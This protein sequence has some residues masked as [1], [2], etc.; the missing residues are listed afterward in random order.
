MSNPSISQLPSTR[1]WLCRLLAAALILGSAALRIAFMASPDCLDL[2]PDEGHYWDW[3]RHPDWSYYSK[4][5]VV[6]L[7]I[8]ASCTL[9]EQ[10]T[11]DLPGQAMLSVRL[12]AVLCGC[13]LLLSVYV[14][15]VLVFQREAWALGAVALGLTLPPIT[16]VSEIMTIDAPYLCCWSWGL[17]F[18]YLALF[19]GKTWGWPL[20]GLMIAVGFLA[21]YTMI[22]FVPS[23]VLFLVFTPR[24]RP[25]LASRGFW[26]MIFVASLGGLPILYWNSQH[27]WVSFKHILG[28]SGFHEPESIHWLGPLSFV[29]MQVGLLMVY[30]FVV[31]I[32]AMWVHRPWQE[33]RADFCFLWWMSMPTFLFFMAFGLKNGGGEPNWPVT[34]YISGMVLAVGWLVAQLNAQAHWYRLTSRLL[35]AVFVGVGLTLLGDDPLHAPGVSTAL[36]FHR[37]ADGRQPDAAQEAGSDLPAARL[38]DPGRGNRSRSS[39]IPRPRRTRTGPG[40]RS[41]VGAGPDRVLLPGTSDGL[42]AGPHRGRP[43]QPVRFLAAQSCGRRRGLSWPRFHPRGRAERPPARSLRPY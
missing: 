21:K 41:L 14:L 39:G 17:I 43:A 25:V 33:P 13:L 4:G 23:L 32:W 11:D 5:P 8:G 37:P 24:W 42:L 6:A 38:A 3:S 40:G 16:A 9:T 7:M 15:T 29:G 12:P 18:A 34:A 20:L 35:L 1:A 28:H 30:W 22:L 27:G 2:S 36:L 26:I 19:R 10:W 31:W